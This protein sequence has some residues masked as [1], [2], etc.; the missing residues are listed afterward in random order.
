M[1]KFDVDWAAEGLEW[2]TLVWDKAQWPLAVGQ[3]NGIP[4]F[5][6]RRKEVPKN[7]KATED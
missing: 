5:Q 4:N 7:R 6:E 3:K 1:S 2:H